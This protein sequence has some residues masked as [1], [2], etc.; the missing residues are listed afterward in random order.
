MICL[1]ALGK[2]SAP[3]ASTISNMPKIPGI[4][5]VQLFEKGSSSP[6]SRGGSIS[7]FS[8]LLEVRDTGPG[9]PAAFL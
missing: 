1:R 6:G 7:T 9:F 2:V 4:K 5:A 3:H 8:Q